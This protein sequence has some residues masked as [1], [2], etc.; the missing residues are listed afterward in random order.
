[1]LKRAFTLVELLVVI[2]II[3]ILAALLL[4]A[5]SRVTGKARRVTCINNLRQVNFGLRMYTDDNGDKLPDTN[6]VMFAYKGLLKAYVGLPAPSSPNDRLFT[7]P[8]DKFSVDINNNVTSGDVHEDPNSNYSSYGFNG[9]NRLSESLPGVAGKKLSSI[10]DSVKT[11]LLAEYA[12]FYGFSWHEIANPPIRNNAPGVVSF[13]DGHVA[14]IRIYWAGHLGKTD[15]PM[16]YDPTNG[17]DYKW[18]AD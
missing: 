7:C 16:W 5:L 10:R 14:Y 3:G 15:S 13:V 4:P 12:V 9:L 8:A 6:A 2:A 1:M 11:V 18:S 17:Y